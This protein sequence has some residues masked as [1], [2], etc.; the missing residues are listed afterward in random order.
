[1]ICLH[2]ILF[3]GFIAFNFIVWSDLKFNPNNLILI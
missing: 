1:M 3:L 2:E